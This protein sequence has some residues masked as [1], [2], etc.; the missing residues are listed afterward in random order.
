MGIEQFSQETVKT[1]TNA[2]DPERIREQD[3]VS[4]FVHIKVT[5]G[6]G[7]QDRGHLRMEDGGIILKAENGVFWRD[8]V[9]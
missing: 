1:L 3:A 5:S 8:F 9:L 7:I 2:C 6:F 4:I